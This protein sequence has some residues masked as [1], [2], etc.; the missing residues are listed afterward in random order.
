MVLKLGALALMQRYPVTRAFHDNIRS[1]L[2]TR[3]PS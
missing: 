3:S 1:S 2:V